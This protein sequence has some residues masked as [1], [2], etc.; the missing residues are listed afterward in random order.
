MYQLHPGFEERMRK[1]LRIF[2]LFD[3]EVEKRVK[4]GLARDGSVVGGASTLG[5]LLR[6]PVRTN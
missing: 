5:T 4:I 6:P 3:E 2:K 1:P